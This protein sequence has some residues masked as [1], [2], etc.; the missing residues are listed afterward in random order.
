FLAPNGVVTDQC[1]GKPC[2][3]DD[4]SPPGS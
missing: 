2:H 1:G 4:Y 3:A